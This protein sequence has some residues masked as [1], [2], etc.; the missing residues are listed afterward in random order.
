MAQ[1]AD[2]PPKNSTKVGSQL[3]SYIFDVRFLGVI[4]QIAFI[5]LV[6]FGVRALIGNF[7]NNADKLGEA[8]FICRDGR[9]SYRCAYDF[10]DNEA[11][12]DIADTTVEYV[13]T[14]SY[15]YAFYVGFLNTLR[16]GL[17]AVVLCTI[18]GLVVGIARLSDNWLIA[19]V[20]LAYVEIIR[21][22]PLLIQLFL[23]YFGVLLA[24][25]NVELA[26]QPFGLP[27]YLS[28]RGLVLPWPRLT[29]GAPIWLAFLVLGIIQFQ[30]MWMH[31]GRVEEKTG[32]GTNRLL[33]CSFVFLLIVGGGWYLTTKFDT[34]EGMLTAKK[35]RIEQTSDIEKL[36]VTRAGL[37]HI[38]GFDDMS[39]E[40][41]AEYALQVCV[42]RDSV[43]EAN[44]T[45][46]L[47]SMGVPYK[48]RRVADASKGA[49]A[50]AEE[51]CE[52]FVAKKSTL[53]AELSTLENPSANRI[54][55]IKESPVVMSVPRLDGFNTSGGLELFPEFFALFLGLAIFYGG[56]LAEVVRAGILSVSKGQTEASR[57]LGLSEPQ[58]LQLIVLPQSL[59]VIIPPLISTYLSLMKD[60]SLGLAVGFADMFLVSRTLLNQSG[61]ALQ[62]MILI[63]LV[64]LTI[65]IVFSLV[66]NAYNK[67]VM[68][69]ER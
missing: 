39:E 37:N 68:I 52:I 57:A 23:I 20:S 8:Q 2:K 15:W 22:T 17:L 11:G 5:F 36:M 59:R 35:S 27:I 19:K 25:P 53:A 45:R 48:I 38:T 30:V 43:S 29:S 26:L 54:V 63:M 7:I 28:N 10:M 56:G 32:R 14:D 40:E 12:F 9:F 69:V 4:G 47:R 44:F 6:I 16:V 13:N 46:Q 41:I 62:I 21:N 66:L 64:Y 3:F 60:T 65:S 49:E 42:L 34:S 24:L 18:I 50:F 1:I 33:R 67:S 58:R 31:Y 61:R 51:K 55:S